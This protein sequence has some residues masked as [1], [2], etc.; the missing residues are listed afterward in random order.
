MGS[1]V[2]AFMIQKIRVNGLWGR[3]SREERIGN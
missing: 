3:Q 2:E 1:K